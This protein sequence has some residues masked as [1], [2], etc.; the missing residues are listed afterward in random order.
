MSVFEAIK[1]QQTK[2]RYDQQIVRNRDLNELFNEM[3]NFAL[4]ESLSVE[5]NTSVQTS[6]LLPILLPIMGPTAQ[7]QLEE[8]LPPSTPCIPSTKEI[9][10]TKSDVSCKPS[11]FSP[12][13]VAV[14]TQNAIWFTELEKLLQNAQQTNQTDNNCLVLTVESVMTGLLSLGF[15]GDTDQMDGGTEIIV[16]PVDVIAEIETMLAKA[17]V[18]S[19]ERFVWIFVMV[20]RT[21]LSF[22]EKSQSEG[23]ILAFAKVTTGLFNSMRTSAQT[24]CSKVF[25][26]L[27]ALHSLCTPDMLSNE[28][29]AGEPD[30]RVLTLKSA[31]IGR[32]VF[33]YSP[34]GVMEGWVW[35]QR[36]AKQLHCCVSA[37]NDSAALLPISG[38]ISQISRSIR[39]FLRFAGPALW[40]AYPER[41]ETCLRSICRVAGSQQDSET[42]K[43]VDFLQ[44]ALAKGTLPVL[45]GR[46]HSAPGSAS[47]EQER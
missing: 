29:A 42:R 9:K 32:S 7:H 33:G 47:A 14:E 25:R 13:F 17:V 40:N 35:L 43:L 19:S 6:K 15:V 11:K 20:S 21:I 44:A 27:L 22:V 28:A 37:L 3:E 8:P 1:E 36:A 46:E 45:D 39:L 31:L 30:F 18:C 26:G 5:V 23:S 4:K 12:P 24:E 2:D 10:K 34:V 41:V 16:D 38:K